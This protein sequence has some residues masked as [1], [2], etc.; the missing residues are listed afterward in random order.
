[1]K[2]LR[3]GIRV[4]SVAITMAAATVS[5]SAAGNLEGSTLVTGTTALINDITKVLAGMSIAIGGGAMTYF[6]IRKAMADET[7]GK[8]YQ[9]RAITA[10][11]CG[12]LGV[13]AAGIV[14]LIAAYYGA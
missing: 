6:L 10:L 8:M 4:L 7:D 9:K 11:I 5:A 3:N 13:L 12:I 2:K 1:M 14:S